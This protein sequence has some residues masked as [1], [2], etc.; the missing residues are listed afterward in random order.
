M[1]H[2]FLDKQFT[3]SKQMD[4]DKPSWAFCTVVQLY[5]QEVVTHFIV[6]YYIK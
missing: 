5:V 4:R 1:G 3:L 2:Y 6:G